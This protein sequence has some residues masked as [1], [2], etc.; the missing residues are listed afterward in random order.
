MTIIKTKLILYNKMQND[1]VQ[2]VFFDDLDEKKEDKR[3]PTQDLFSFLYN[4]FF[5]TGIDTNKQ[6]AT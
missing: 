5:S 6:K 1:E 2:Y 4:M 3:E